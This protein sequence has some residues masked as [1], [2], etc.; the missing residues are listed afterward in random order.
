MGVKESLG[1]A[2]WVFIVIDMLVVGAV[3]AGPEEHGVLKGS[4]A[5]D[6]RKEPNAPMRLESEVRV[7]PVIAERDG[8]AAG[9]EHHKEERDLEPVDSKEPEICWYGGERQKQG[10]D[11][12]RAGWPVDFLERDS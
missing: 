1:D 10:A 12:K 3:F 4:G 11:E 8:K 9:A 2:V 6:Q 7:E 5:E